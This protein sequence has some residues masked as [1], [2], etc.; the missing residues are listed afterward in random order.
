MDPHGTL[1]LTLPAAAPARSPRRAPGSAT[2]SSPNSSDGAVETLRL[3]VSEVVTNAV[4]HGD[5]GQPVELH[6]SWNSEVRVEVSTTATAS[7]RRRGSARWTSPA[8]SASSSSAA[9]RT[10]GASRPTT[11]PPSG[12]SCSADG[13]ACGSVPS[14]TSTTGPSSWKITE[15]ADLRGDRLLVV[16][17][18][19][20]I[21]TAPE[22]VEMLHRLRHQGHA[23]AGRS[24]RGDVH[25]LDRADDADGRPS[26][27][28]E[29]RLVVRGPPRRR[30]PSAASSSSPV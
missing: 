22:L 17:G 3:L 16:H 29:Q 18:E 6:A 21:A 5:D 8:A 26:R 13:A 24:G 30:P 27:G 11:A 19:L 9:S 15:V 12:S 20:D 23:V 10:A 7:R 1:D 2:R 28:R 4:R 14:T 25:G